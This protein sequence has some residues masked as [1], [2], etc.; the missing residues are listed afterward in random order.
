M[1]VR[2]RVLERAARD[3]RR[4]F[5]GRGREEI[6]FRLRRDRLELLDRRRAVHVAGNDQDLLLLFPQ[7]T[8]KL[9]RGRG[10]AGALQ[11]RHQYHGGRLRGEVESDVGV[12]HQVGQFAMH[13]AHQRL[14]RSQ[15]AD[16]VLA[17]RFLAHGRDEVLDHRH[18]AV[19]LEQRDPD[20]AQRVLNI[21]LGEAGLAAQRLDDAP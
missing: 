19:G 15:A 17:E 6:R 18:G 4:R 16:H 5:V 1:V 21:G 7:Q 10:L 8:G 20:L 11:A 13:D 14:T 9:A 3:V 12:A 2:L